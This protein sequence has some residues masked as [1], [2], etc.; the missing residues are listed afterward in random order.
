MIA[1]ENIELLT[2]KYQTDVITVWREYFQHLFLSYF[3][4][5]EHADKI[6]FKGGTALRL[7]YKSPRFSEDIDFS[8]TLQE[9]F[10]IET[11]VI[12]TLAEIARERIQVDI[13]DAT[14]TTGGYLAVLV[15]KNN[16]DTMPIR[17]EISLRTNKNIGQ[18]STVSGDFLP[19]YTVFQL[20]EQQLVNEK[21]AAL[22]SRQKPRDFYDTYF[23][24]RNNMIS[25]KNSELLQKILALVQQTTIRFD[26]ELK[27]YLPKSHWMIIRDF[28]QTLER[29]IK[30]YV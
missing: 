14:P 10:S 1:R 9:V 5:Q 15:F 19:P 11:I 18:F 25:E 28:K 4:Q 20:T 8:S 16:G 12:A 21:I 27:R 26:N 24:L 29:E 13:K 23:L 6:F 17:L 3:Y 30:R 7:L 2:R 22:L